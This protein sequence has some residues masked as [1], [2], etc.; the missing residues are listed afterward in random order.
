VAGALI[1]PTSNFTICR[2]CN[3]GQTPRRLRANTPVAC[4]SPIDLND[5]VNKAM[6]TVDLQGSSTA[7]IVEDESKLPPHEERMKFLKEK[8]L[9]LNN[10]NLTPA[11]F[12]Q[13]SALL[14]Q[15][16]EI[17][18]SDIEQLPESALPPCHIYL[19]N[20][21]P[22]RQRRYPLPPAHERVLDKFIDKYLK[23]EIIVPARSGWHAPCLS[24]R[25]ANSIQ[26]NPKIYQ[27]GD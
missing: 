7:P 22:I 10:A 27:I 4:I 1:H 2:I 24:V 3:I 21:K 20:D 13:L 17:F 6:M 15:Y 23:S 26:L 18:C 14:Y 5:P 25:K 11:Q 19:K 9:P 16:E 8:G 12:S